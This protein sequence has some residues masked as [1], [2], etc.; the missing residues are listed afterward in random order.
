M[1]DKYTLFDLPISPDQISVLLPPSELRKIDFS[2]LDF[3]TARRAQVE[4]IK[5]YYSGDFNDFV[6][7]NGVIMLLELNAYLTAIIAQRGDLN[8][9]EGFL[10][11]SES[12]DAVMN[13][14]AL[15]NQKI[16]RATPAVT[17]IACTV[18][19]PVPTDIHIPAGT[20]F[21]I[22]GDSGTIT[23]EVYRSPVDFISDIIIPAGK[24]GL[25]AFG[26]EGKFQF[27]TTT[28]DGSA[29]QRITIN[30]NTN[31]IET[32]VRVDVSIGNLTEE[33]Q[34]I[35]CIDKAGPQDKVYEPRFFANRAEFLFGDNITG[36]ALPGGATITISY[37]I[38][39]GVRGRI[40]SGAI[41]EDRYIAPQY[42]FTAPI[43]VNFRNVTPSSGGQDAESIANAK[44]RAP[45]D[46][47]T[48]LSAV[49]PG[50]YAQLV[51]S[52]NHPVF[53]SVAKSIAT[54][55]T[56]LNA[57]RVELYVLAEGPSGPIA[58][59]QGLKRAIEQYIDEINV[60]TDHVVVLDAKIHPVD[61]DLTIVMGRSTDASVIKTRVEAA[62]TEF[63][64]IRNWDLGQPFY[65]SSLYNILS[66]LDGVRYVDIFQPSDNILASGQLA[67]SSNTVGINE[68][69]TLGNKQIKYYYETVR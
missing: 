13:H 6:S 22:P 65:I 43:S 56:S 55:R 9:G 32:P 57:N 15:I 40:G 29:S 42:P 64:D 38:G 39:G 34:Q 53:G 69:I 37:R 46:F 20:Q 61:I 30:S 8:A 27:V 1:T 3:A 12:D 28:S 59:N 54:L 11:S 18:D 2:A 21:T 58:P 23:Y 51:Q 16:R 68:L 50:D 33:W 24:R 7:N 14:L 36:T 67:D 25:I 19:D 17:D 66:S 5:A 48:H 35:D 47:A 44:K 31:I 62:I 60:L 26:I 45:R 63:F 41:D 4:Y 49:T 52:F 10:A